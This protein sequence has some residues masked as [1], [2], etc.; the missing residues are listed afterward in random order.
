MTWPIK[1]RSWKISSVLCLHNQHRKHNKPLSF[2]TISSLF[3]H[4]NLSNQLVAP[5]KKSWM[6]KNFSCTTKNPPGKWHVCERAGA[7]FQKSREVSS[8]IF[9]IN[10]K[11]KGSVGPSWRGPKMM[12]RSWLG[13][14]F[15]SYQFRRHHSSRFLT[16]PTCKSFRLRFQLQ[17]SLISLVKTPT[18]DY[19]P[20]QNTRASNW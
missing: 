8:N 17:A 11:G 1:T 12:M 16:C 3:A 9:S 5:A 2:S 6:S 4:E 19:T 14:Q 15:L 13:G 7:R 18:I 20:R 10:G